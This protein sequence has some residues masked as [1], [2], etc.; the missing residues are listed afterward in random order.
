MS[1]PFKSSA[2][3]IV[4][5]VRAFCEREK[6]NEAPL[7]RL[8]QVRAR[9]A[10]MTGMSE[11]TVSRITKKGEVAASTSQELKS[12]GKHRQKRKTVDLDDFDL[13]ALRNKI[14]EMYTV[15]KVVPTLNKLLIELRNDINF[16]GGRTTLWKILKRIEFKYKNCGSKRKILMERHDIVT[17][18][19][20]YI[21]TMRQNRVEGRPIVFLD[22]TYIH[23]SN[24]VQ[25]CWQKGDEDGVLTSDSP[26][27]RW[28]IVN[29]GGEMG[30]V[31]NA[32]LIFKSQSKSGDYHD[33]I[34]RT[35]FMKCLSEKLIP[36]LP[37]NSLVVMDN[38]PYHT[39]Q[40]NKAPTMSSSKVQMQE[41]ITN[42]ELSYLPTMLKAE[43]YQIIKKH[44]E[45]P[46]YEADQLLISHGHKVFRLPHY[47]CDLN[48]I[49][50]MWSLLKRRV[51]SNNPVYNIIMRLG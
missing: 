9:V 5:K 7:I 27:T 44:K 46:I 13:C 25:K 47:H 48:V 11:K 38:A 21:D 43:L 41:W 20:K 26:G 22:E 30:F 15:R 49:E 17:W 23:A 51:A 33:D 8:D 24:A 3:E 40:V 10:A 42:K 37:P 36:N 34:N 32:Q 45:A 50:F 12:P 14:H 2:R 18:R 35:N 28:I 4:L 16:G 31:S 6:A 19:R 39:V 29:A 1:K